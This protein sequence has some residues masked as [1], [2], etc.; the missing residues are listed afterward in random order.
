MAWQSSNSA[1]AQWGDQ[2]NRQGWSAPQWGNQD[3]RQGWTAPMNYVAFPPLVP[4]A[5][6][7]PPPPPLPQSDRP[8]GRPQ[9]QG[10]VPAVPGQG[11][12]PQ[13]GYQ[14]QG[15][16]APGHL[17]QG[18]QSHPQTHAL[19]QHMHPSQGHHSHQQLLGHL[20]Q[21]HQSHHDVQGQHHRRHRTTTP[22]ASLVKDFSDTANPAAV[23]AQALNPITFAKFI[24]E[25]IEKLGPSDFNQIFWQLSPT[26]RAAAYGLPPGVTTD[27][28]SLPTPQQP[29]M[30]VKL[31]DLRRE[32]CLN[33]SEA[34]QRH[35]WAN[36]TW[37]LVPMSRVTKE[38]FWEMMRTIPLSTEDPTR[39]NNAST[40][41]KKCPVEPDR[42]FS[43][44]AKHVDQNA[45]GGAMF[46][47]EPPPGAA[48]ANV[49]RD[50]RVRRQSRSRSRRSRSAVAPP[51]GAGRNDRY[52]SPP[53]GGRENAR[54]LPPG[55]GINR[56]RALV[57]AS[58]K[59][60]ARPRGRHV[61]R[62]PSDAADFE[63]FVAESVEAEANQF[64]LKDFF[65]K[66]KMKLK[67][68]STP[69]NAL[70]E[71]ASMSVMSEL[72]KNVFNVYHRCLTKAVDG[73][74]KTSR[75]YR[76][77]KSMAEALNLDMTRADDKG[78]VEVL[79]RLRSLEL[80]EKPPS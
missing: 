44:Y 17:P 40:Y 47:D 46:R 33:L 70:K 21:G 13:Q 36:Q 61:Q 28:K 2:G 51:P 56:L 77:L 57:A 63:V 29:A 32:R 80:V 71:M 55:A 58:P 15:H 3:N 54:S 69:S 19:S 35:N 37:D 73:L 16:I 43:D 20:P 25:C 7:H 45:M 27:I 38:H 65:I 39:W 75:E 9:S 1:Q 76:Q 64:T 23:L 78:L 24:G 52:H 48:C 18:H 14:L 42:K 34:S 5:G 26:L 50:A 79:A 41:M 53:P 8:E 31:R 6:V 68:K 59:G 67:K 72:F 11:L 10:F 12:S 49:N 22:E 66:S 62:L 60:M 74:A 4:E 30:C